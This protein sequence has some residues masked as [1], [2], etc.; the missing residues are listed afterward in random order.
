MVLSLKERRIENH[1]DKLSFFIGPGDQTGT[2]NNLL[3]VNSAHRSI[4]T[5]VGSVAEDKVQVN[6][7]RFRTKNERLRATAV[8]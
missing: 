4:E 2:T 5:I 7:P 3:T 1:G 6:D 8:A